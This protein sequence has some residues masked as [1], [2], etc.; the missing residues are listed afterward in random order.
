[1]A[2][3][4]R[5]TVTFL[6]TDIEGSTRLLKQLGAQYSDV[7]DAHRRILREAV[8]AREGREVD[9][10]GDSFFFAFARANAALGAAVAAQRALAEHEWPEGAEVRVRM[11]LHT[12]EPAVGQERYVGLG[13]H[14]AARIGAVAHGGQVLLSSATRELVEDELGGVSVRELGAYRLKDIDRPEQL[15]Q[16]DIEG[17]QTQ[18][19]PLRAE[20]LAEP[21]LLRRHSLLAAAL[22]GVL[23]AAVGVP[24]FALSSGG[25]GNS[26]ASAG[27]G[28]NAVAAIDAA[29]RPLGSIPLEASPNSI[30][31]GDGSLWV[32]MPNQDSVSR[33]DPT[34]K[35]VQQTIAAGKG[36]AG[37]A[38]GGG[39]IW[40]ANSLEGTVWQIDPRR[41]GGE[42]VNKIGVGNGPTGVAYGLGAVWVANSSDRTVVRI[43]PLNGA[44]G[45]PIPVDSGADAVAVG[46]GAVWVTSESAGVV[47]RIDPGSGSVTRTIGVGNAPVAVSTGAGSV[48]VANSGDASVYRIDPAKNRVATAIQVGEGPSGVTVAPDGK[49]IWVSNDLAGTLSRIDPALN[50]VV[51]TVAVGGRPQGVAV[52]RD[53]AYAALRG[54]GIAHRGG[55]LTVAVVGP[56]GVYSAKL[57]EA[58]DPAYGYASWELLTLTNGGLVGYGRSGG[59]NAYKV[60]PDLALTLPTVTDGGRTYSFELRPGIRYS[61]GGLVGPADVRRGIERAL[62]TSGDGIPTSYLS[63]IDGAAGCITTPKRCDLSRGIVTDSTANTITFHLA[64]PDP[65]FIYKLAL[66]IADAVPAGTPL[67]ARL[68]LPATGPYQI[69]SIDTKRAVIRLVR[70]PHFRLWSAAAQ[71]D[72]F[73]DQ[74]VEK[75]GYTG[76]S[77]IQ[78]VE[79]GTAD[80]TAEDAALPAAVVSALRT[81]Y[82][83]RV[84][85]APILDTV[86]V[87]LN[88]RLPPFNDVRVRRAVNYAVDRNHLIDLASGPDRAR[89]GCQLLPP[90]IN[91]YRRYC[92]YTLHPNPAG[93]YNGPD[94]AKARRL[95]TASGTKGQSIT[96]WFYSIPI[97]VRNGEY[98]VSVLRSLGYKARLKTIPHTAGSTFNR[99]RQAGVGGA[100][101]DYPSPNNFFA[102]YFSCRSYQ[103]NLPNVNANFAAFCNPHIDAQIVRAGALQS[104]D[105][106]AAS[107][108]WSTIDREI[109]DQAPWV[110]I[111]NDLAPSFVSRRTGNYTFCFLS[112]GACLDDLWVR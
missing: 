110:A 16:L 47:S 62:L 64:A 112:L 60:V 59:A 69:A 31:S 104:S 43:D 78:A 56:P 45:Q 23:A 83:S 111:R 94:L 48:W 91:G 29:G 77:A 5:G 27:P 80:I 26:P 82:S 96:V 33:I 15:S 18:F 61:T 54:S 36:P 71:P 63:G 21:H 22:V 57:P 35:T 34:T 7:L 53:T 90:N 99:H 30:A 109:T 92:P 87:W 12:G 84:Y 58:L 9:T 39:F 75:Y 32:T 25:S 50:K 20:R 100:T 44:P 3:L 19:P 95:V 55:T 73:P 107:Q 102:A 74:I 106:H 81:R 103:P 70:N 46:S 93:T 24:L 10:Q 52:N 49:S 17:L 37:I 68:P 11:G 86:A 88:T 13:V 14:R 40:V 89:V 72:G 41:N 2:E 108:L 67:Q 38:V 97:G 51:K 6:F 66:P 101:A 65:D 85:G 105:P 4:P 79:H 1:V 28:A 76:E 8:E 42:A 98:I